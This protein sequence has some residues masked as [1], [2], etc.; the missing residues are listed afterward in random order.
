MEIVNPS[1][2][3]MTGDYLIVS[4]NGNLNVNLWKEY[5]NNEIV[6]GDKSKKNKQKAN[7]PDMKVK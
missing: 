1:K 7:K 3:N 4:E 6:I 5:V 2:D